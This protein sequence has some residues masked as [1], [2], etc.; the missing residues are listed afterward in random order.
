MNF[1]QPY[2]GGNMQHAGPVACEPYSAVPSILSIKHEVNDL[3]CPPPWFTRLDMDLLKHLLATFAQE[4]MIL[5]G[6]SPWGIWGIK[7]DLHD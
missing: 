1:Q 5:F 6:Y 3:F 7:M 2:S 4:K